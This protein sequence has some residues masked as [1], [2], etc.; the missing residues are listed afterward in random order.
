M[1]GKVLQEV[2]RMA[3]LRQNIKCLPANR[4]QRQSPQQFLKAFVCRVPPVFH[5]VTANNKHVIPAMLPYL[6]FIDSEKIPTR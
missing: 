5:S 1:N 6:R 2:S 4:A 3:E